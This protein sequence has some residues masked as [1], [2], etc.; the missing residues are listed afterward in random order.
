[1]LWIA[2]LLP[3]LSLD[4]FARASADAHAA[5]PFVVGSGGH[6]PRVVAANETAR[7]AGIVAGQLVS[8]AL[9]LAPDV[10]IRDRDV[11]SEEATLRE[12]ART[13][14]GKVSVLAAPSL[15]GAA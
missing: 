9:A 4:V 14:A 6:Y 10:A 13:V 8:A 3:T 1:M 15:V 5:H 2:V 12:V 7:A 11:A